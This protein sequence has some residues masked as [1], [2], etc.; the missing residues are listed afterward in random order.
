MKR[1]FR[2]RTVT[3]W[4]W[5][6]MSPPRTAACRIALIDARILILILTFLQ[7][8]GAHVADHQVREAV[9]VVEAG[10]AR[11]RDGRLRD[12]AGERKVRHLV[13]VVSRRP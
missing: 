2:L 10:E 8:G 3:C 7:Q 11:G 9:G 12:A 13:V 1:P 5:R 6:A 4:N